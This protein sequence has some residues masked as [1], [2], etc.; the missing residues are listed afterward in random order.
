EGST[1]QCA[2]KGHNHGMGLNVVMEYP[3]TGGECWI[4]ML[5]DDGTPWRYVNTVTGDYRDTL[6][7]GGEVSKRVGS[8]EAIEKR[9]GVK[10]APA[11]KVKAPRKKKEPTPVE[12][13]VVAIMGQVQRTT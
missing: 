8:K 2:C 4:E 12:K 7:P 13:A 1:C 10:P 11:A 5:Q 3:T 9:T 6:P